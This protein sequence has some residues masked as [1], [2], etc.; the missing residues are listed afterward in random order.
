[1]STLG[2]LWNVFRRRRIDDELR[3]EIETHLALLEQDAQAHGASADQAR[4]DARARFG[5]AVVY[6]ERAREAI[7]AIWL[8]QAGK[9]LVFALRRLRRSP[10]FTTAAVLTLALAIGANAAIFAVVERVVLNPLPYPDS[11]RVIQ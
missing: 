3:R 7:I 5:N 2:R 10:I 11:D 8:E 4:I 1:M 9:E 6:R